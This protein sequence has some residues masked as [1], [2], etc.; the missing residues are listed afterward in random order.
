MRFGEPPHKVICA[1]HAND[2]TRRQN[3]ARRP[4][5]PRKY[6]VLRPESANKRKH[7]S[8]SPT[9]APRLQRSHISRGGARS[10][11]SRRSH[12]IPTRAHRSLPTA[13]LAL[14]LPP[15]NRR[16]FSFCHFADSHF[17]SRPFARG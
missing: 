6:P 15:P 17:H 14:Q 1:E 4:R 8:S 10:L 3:G 2:V 5:R 12:T 16:A 9:V 13:T 7:Q 11:P